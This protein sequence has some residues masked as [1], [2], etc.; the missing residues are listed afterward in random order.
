LLD[1][2]ARPPCRGR[3]RGVVASF[4]KLIYWWA[5]YTVGFGIDI[6]PRLAAGTFVLFDRYYL[7]L[8]VDPI[9]Y[10]YGG[11]DWLVTLV[12]RVIPQPNAFIVL[13]APAV[14][15]KSRK[16]ELTHEEASLQMEA[17]EEMAG[18]SKRIYLVDASASIDDTAA[19]AE[20]IV[21]DLLEQRVAN[22]FASRLPDDASCLRPAE[23]DGAS[24]V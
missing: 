19:V 24:A 5:D 13:G 8:Y 20:R 16:D 9:R 11:P 17:Y 7:D 6:F 23:T 2:A 15:L 3:P 18:R 10:R 22:R 1:A 21:L 12:D 4:L 14:T